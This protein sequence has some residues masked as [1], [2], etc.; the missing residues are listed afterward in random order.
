LRENGDWD[1]DTNLSNDFSMMEH[2]PLNIG[3]SSYIAD[4]IENV[5]YIL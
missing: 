2:P 5:Q 4:I 1:L 3:I